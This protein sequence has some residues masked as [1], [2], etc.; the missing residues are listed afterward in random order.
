M[1]PGDEKKKALKNR[2]DTILQEAEAEFDKKLRAEMEGLNDELGRRLNS[3]LSDKEKKLGDEMREIDELAQ[4]AENGTVNVQTYENK[5][6]I[7]SETA[8]CLEEILRQGERER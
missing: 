5:R 7:L 8:A 1:Q 2:M 4:K 3:D 6:L